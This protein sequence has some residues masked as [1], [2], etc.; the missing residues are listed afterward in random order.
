LEREGVVAAMVHISHRS[1]LPRAADVVARWLK[2]RW[3]RAVV[4]ACVQRPLLAFAS[5]V[6]G[7]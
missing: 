3:S 1:L 4:D 6:A 2:H 5:V 7:D